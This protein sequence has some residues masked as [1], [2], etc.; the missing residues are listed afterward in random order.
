MRCLTRL[1]LRG[2]DLS[3]FAITALAVIYSTVI[4][5]ITH[6]TFPRPFVCSPVCMQHASVHAR[7]WLFTVF[8]LDL[9]SLF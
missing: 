9:L 2:L 5:N 8:T 7:I 1:I 4:Y 3:F 6:I